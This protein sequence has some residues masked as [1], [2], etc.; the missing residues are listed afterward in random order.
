MRVST[1]KQGTPE[2]K[3]ER[4]GHLTGSRLADIMPDKNGKYMKVRSDLAMQMAVERLY[5]APIEGPIAAA[6]IWGQDA[7]P[8]ARDETE[9]RTGEFIQQVGF[10]WHPTWRWVGVSVDGLIGS[11][12]TYE[13]KCPKN[14]MNHMRTWQTGKMPDE[15]IPQ[16]QGQLWVTGRQWCLFVSYDPRA[17][18]EFRL[19]MTRVY[20]DELYIARL[21]KE[22][23]TF[24]G[25]VN[26]I[27]KLLKLKAK[28]AA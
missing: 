28:E 25:E 16:V 17:P 11:D 14:P 18:K 15:H 21:A 27:V 22:V 13:S 9:I 6:L 23:K 8:F 26:L 7:E 2:W 24:L 20:R 4:A 3:M 5:N 19:F 12:G 1:A 10:I